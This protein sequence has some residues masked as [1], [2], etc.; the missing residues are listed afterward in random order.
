M[1]EAVKVALNL[2]RAI[3]A[4]DGEVA[5]FYKGTNVREELTKALAGESDE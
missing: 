5:V 1:E 4:S 2:V 3:E